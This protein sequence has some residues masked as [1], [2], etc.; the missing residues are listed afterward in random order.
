MVSELEITIFDQFKCILQSSMTFNSDI[1][2]FLLDTQL[3]RTKAMT[4]KL[5]DN[6]L[7]KI[8]LFDRETQ[9]LIAHPLKKKILN[10][11]FERIYHGDSLKSILAT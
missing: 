4:I 1:E 11:A 7:T 8:F 3:E 5:F 10:C 9:L 2:C 6:K